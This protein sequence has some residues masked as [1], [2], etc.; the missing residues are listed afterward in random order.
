MLM[1]I[2]TIVLYLLGGRYILQIVDC[3]I[4]EAKG[5]FIHGFLL[6]DSDRNINSSPSASQYVLKEV[7]E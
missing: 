1:A 3:L 7:I 6:G 2:H 4:N 5:I